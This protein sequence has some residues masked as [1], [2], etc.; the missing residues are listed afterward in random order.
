MGVCLL[1]NCQVDSRALLACMAPLQA[2][3]SCASC[4]RLNRAAVRACAAAH[5]R[6]CMSWHRVPHFNPVL[7]RVWRGCAAAA[8]ALLGGRPVPGGPGLP[9]PVQQQ[10]GRAGL[11]GAP[12]FRCMGTA[13]ATQMVLDTTATVEY[14]A[15]LNLCTNR[16][17][18]ICLLCLCCPAAGS[19]TVNSASRPTAA[20]CRQ[21]CARRQP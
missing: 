8:G 7:K 9:Q 21:A 17:E 3:N 11:S 16:K 19:G 4:Q 15:C 5:I 1:G 6:S 10:E 2:A 18:Q 12:L 14:L 20:A 13:T